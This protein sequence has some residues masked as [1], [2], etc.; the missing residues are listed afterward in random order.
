MNRHVK[1]IG[2]VTRKYLPLTETFVHQ[3]I[4]RNKWFQNI[5]F[6]KKMINE[7]RFPVDHLIKVDNEKELQTALEGN[8]IELIHAHFGPSALYTLQAKQS[9]GIP[10]LTFIHGYD[11]KKYPL[12]KRENLR[13]YHDLF[14]KCEAFAVPS[15]AIKK[16][17]LSLGCPNE[18]ITVHHL[19]I[20]VDQFTFRPRKL[21]GKT[22]RLIS[23]GRLIEKKGHHH[24]IEALSIVKNNVPNFHL[25][26]IGEGSMR[27]TLEKLIDKFHLQNEIT[28][29]GQQFHHRV[30]EKLNDSHIFCLPSVTEKN[31][32]MEGLPVSILEAQAMGLPIIS[33]KHSGIPEGVVDGKSGLLSKEGDIDELA[34]NLITLMNDTGVWEEFGFT[35]RKWVEK[36]FHADK[37]ALELKTL[38]D[39]ILEGEFT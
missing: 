10:M 8:R 7:D 36:H 37:Q 2:H 15:K 4:I 3:Q 34:K 18:K 16:E 19:G 27:H 32:N 21:D 29:L 38:Y 9:L 11:A 39:R 17:L 12:S 23:V 13:K 30:L 24:L 28:L 20:D 33:T 35:G 6:T 1:K 5:V 25:T 22:I 26:I 14:N 31:G